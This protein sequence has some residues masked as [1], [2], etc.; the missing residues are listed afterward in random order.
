MHAPTE[1]QTQL[2]AENPEFKTIVLDLRRDALTI[3][4]IAVGVI[5][6]SGIK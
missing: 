4:G 1:R 2:L 3:E 6:N 5:R